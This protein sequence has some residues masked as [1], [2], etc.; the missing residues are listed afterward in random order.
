MRTSL[1]DIALIERYLM[2]QL[3]ESDARDVNIRLGIDFNFRM[4][5][6]LQH[7]VYTLLRQYFKKQV[8]ARAELVHRNVFDHPSKSLY[9]QSVYELFKKK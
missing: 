6:F 7:K 1:N 2:K 3:S 9:R 4:H 5:L 8:R